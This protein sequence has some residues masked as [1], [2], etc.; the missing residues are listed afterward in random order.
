MIRPSEHG[1]NPPS[2]EHT[3]ETEFKTILEFLARTEENM[4]TAA[5]DFK[6]TRIQRLHG[7]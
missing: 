4:M 3:F 1:N 5:Q 6:K 7:L 2:E